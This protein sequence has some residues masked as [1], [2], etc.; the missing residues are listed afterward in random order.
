MVEILGE[1]KGI[2]SPTLRGRLQSFLE[3]GSS[4]P[5]KG[6]IPQ[7]HHLRGMMHPRSREETSYLLHPSVEDQK[8]GPRIL[9]GSRILLHLDTQIFKPVQTTL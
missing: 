5:A 6:P 3:K 7:I 2:A 4:L 1:D 8:G 9:G